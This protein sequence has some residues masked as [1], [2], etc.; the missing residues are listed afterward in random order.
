MIQHVKKLV[1]LPVV[2]A[3]VTLGAVAWTT[4]PRA[5]ADTAS[6]ASHADN[7]NVVGAW[8][9]TA[10]APYAP[11]LFTFNAD[12]T[13]LST[14]P[15]NVQE[16]PAKPHGGTNDSVGMGVW[17]TVNQHGKT[18]VVGT[19]EELNA[20]ADTHQPT[21]TLSVSFKISVT[22][23]TLDGPAVAKQGSEVNPSHL[24]GTR[25]SIDDAAVSSL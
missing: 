15:T 17:K 6:V 18:Y 13:M 25:L 22:G 24:S 23:D 2:I 3:A 14:N 11:H 10:A 1:V 4:G 16:N 5:S 9:I 19:F 8:E 12:G 7:A 21:D 20:L